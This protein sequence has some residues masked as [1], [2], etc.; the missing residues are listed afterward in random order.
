MDIRFVE[1]LVA[2][3]EVGSLAAAARQ[4]NLTAAAISQ[5]V[6]ALEAELHVAL[7]LR[8]GRRVVPTPDCEALL[9]DFN[10]MLRIRAGLKQRLMQGRLKGTFRLGAISTAIGDYAP[11]LVEVLRAEAPEVELSL[12]P[13]SSSEIFHKFESEALDAALIVEPP[14]VLPK[15]MVFEVVGRQPLGL[16]T[17]K[18]PGQD[19]PYIVYGREAWGGSACWAALERLE[20]APRILCE[21]D[22]LETIAQMVGDGLGQALLPRWEGLLRHFPQTCFA[23]IDASARNVGLLSWRRDRDRPVMELLRQGLGLAQGVTPS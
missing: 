7:L 20:T 16:L 8:E 11:G 19:L 22:A 6:A 2:V 10:R 12:M 21:M 1:S 4:Q 3:V 15:S 18:E 9:P 17:P 23:P 14:F 13:G 5:R